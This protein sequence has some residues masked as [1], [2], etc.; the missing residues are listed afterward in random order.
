MRG[1]YAYGLGS[2]V[3]VAFGIGLGF[4][5]SRLFRCPLLLARAARAVV[6]F[7]Q[8]VGRHMGRVGSAA[9]GLGV[10]PRKLG[11]RPLVLDWELLPV[12]QNSPKQ[13]RLGSNNLAQNR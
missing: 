7:V 8:I 1:R 5:R 2:A 10:R 11:L 4:P 6:S 3:Y 12:K 13:R 9:F